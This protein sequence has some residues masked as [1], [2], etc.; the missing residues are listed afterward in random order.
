M[1]SGRG[2]DED[3]KQ[4]SILLHIERGRLACLSPLSLS[5]NSSR[6]P[7]VPHISVLKDTSNHYNVCIAL[8]LNR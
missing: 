4:A 5:L 2:R 3:S 1:C 8:E 6:F 7:Y